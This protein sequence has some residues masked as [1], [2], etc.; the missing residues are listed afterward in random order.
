MY[1]R[2]VRMRE[3]CTFEAMLSS[4]CRASSA[5]SLK[6]RSTFFGS[7]VFVCASDACK[8]D[9]GDRRKDL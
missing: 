6:P 4:S 9:D 5:F 3:T 8:Q 7:S 2:R 1:L